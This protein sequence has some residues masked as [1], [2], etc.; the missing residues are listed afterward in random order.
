MEPTDAG[1]VEWDRE[2]LTQEAS[3]PEEDELA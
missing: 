3:C 1:V 2:D